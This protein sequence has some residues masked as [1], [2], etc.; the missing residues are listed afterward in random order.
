MGG[1]G[2]AGV[3]NTGGESIGEGDVMHLYGGGLNKNQ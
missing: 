3:G 1:S 2:K